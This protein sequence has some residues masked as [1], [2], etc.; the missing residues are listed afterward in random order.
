MKID[1]SYVGME[2]A[3]SYTSWTKRS[4]SASLLEVQ[5]AKQGSEDTKGMFSDLLGAGKEEGQVDQIPQAQRFSSRFGNY[6][7]K[8]ASLEEKR[9]LQTIREQCVLFLIKWLYDNLGSKRTRSEDNANDCKAIDLGAQMN[10]QQPVPMGELPK[11]KMLQ[12]RMNYEHV[13]QEQTSFQTQGV[14]RT[15]DGREISFGMNLSMSR[16]FEE[17]YQSVN[18]KELVQMTDP[19]VINLDTSMTTLSDQKFEFD[20]DH[21]GI[22]DSISMLGEGSGFLALDKNGDGVI[23]DGS[24]LFGTKSGD[25]FRD[26]AAYDEDGNGWID[27]NDAIFDKLLIWAKTESGKDELYTL[28]EAGV[29]AICLQKA[30]T[31]F[32]LN[33][34]RDN[35]KNGMIRSTGMFLYENGMTGTMQQ[36]DLAQ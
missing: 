23:N 25:G 6:E 28:K 12:V 29:G 32:S 22:K 10:Q 1:S 4:V 9:Q 31:E 35:Q 34:L 2:S 21:D 18:T 24:E 8:I 30:D 26:L 19:L 5:A 20:L 16:R 3:R 27:E 13:E 15:A 36:L 14:V 17:Y 7:N 11:Q 33:S